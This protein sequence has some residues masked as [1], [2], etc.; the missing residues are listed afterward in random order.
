MTKP[1]YGDLPDQVIPE[2]LFVFTT[3]DS[4]KP[5]L[6]E[7]DTDDKGLEELALMIRSDSIIAV[8]RGTRVKA[9]VTSQ[10]QI[11]LGNTGYTHVL[12]VKTSP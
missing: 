6:I 7:L 5:K 12:N 1:F 4:D 3:D 8:V 11:D 9:Q 2:K 10:V